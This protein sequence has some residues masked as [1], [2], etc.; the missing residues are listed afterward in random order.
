[1]KVQRNNEHLRNFLQK[2]G[3]EKTLELNTGQALWD[4]SCILSNNP[5]EERWKDKTKSPDLFEAEAK[6]KFFSYVADERNDSI[7]GGKDNRIK[8]SYS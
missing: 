2:G 7:P 8:K 4:D 1:M 3:Q 5:N 6:T